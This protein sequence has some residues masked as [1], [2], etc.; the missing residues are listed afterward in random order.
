MFHTSFFIIYSHLIGNYYLAMIFVYSTCQKHSDLVWQRHAV[1]TGLDK[2]HIHMTVYFPVEIY[3]M[4]PLSKQVTFLIRQMKLANDIFLL[5]ESPSGYNVLRT[6]FTSLA[7]YKCQTH[8]GP[9][10]MTTCA[11]HGRLKQITVYPE[12]GQFRSGWELTL[13]TGCYKGLIILT[14]RKSSILFCGKI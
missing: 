8:N 14:K 7:T 12:V 4:C 1:G 2:K 6:V 9:D 10:G 13:V 5:P 11:M 3:H